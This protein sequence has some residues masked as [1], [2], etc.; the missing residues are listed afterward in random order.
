MA[1]VDDRP[2]LRERKKAATR[3]AILSHAQRLFE[4]RGYDRVTVAEIADAAD[5]S[6]KTLFVYFRSKE[7]L[8]FADTWL[9]D[10]LAHE[11]RHRP[12]G[13]SH[14]QAVG[15]VLDRALTADP[16]AGGLEGFHRGIGETDALRSRLLRMWADYEDVVAGVL[17]EEGGLPAPHP[18]L[19][20]AAT[21]LVGIAR[22]FTSSEVRELA[23][24]DPAAETEVLRD[25]L[26]DAV[27]Q[28]DH[29]LAGTLDRG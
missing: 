10:A 29:G 14:A 18:A 1:H 21:Q 28:V 24:R 15:A 19:R 22:S 7:D 8:A 26:R 5:I 20:L 27:A 3:A 2:S 6:V 17:A 4:E 25:W 11:L 23:R 9:V 13:T 12:P 16:G